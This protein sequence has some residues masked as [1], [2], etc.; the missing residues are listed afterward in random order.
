MQLSLQNFS[1]LVEGMAASVQGAAQSLLDL[2]VGSV[3]RAILEANASIALWLQWLIVQVLATTRL[4]TSSGAD[5]DSFGADFGFVR[6][7]A[8][9]AVGQVTFSR[10]T[11]SIAAF[12]PVGTNVSVVANT[13]SFV[14]VADTTNPSYS[15]ALGGYTLA[16]GVASLNVT[17]AASI[18]GSAGNVQPGSIALMSSAVSGVDTVTNMG[19]LTGG[20]DAESDAAFRARFGNYL[21]SLSRATDIAI[22]STIAGIQQG[23]SYT[24][25]ENINQAGNAQMGNFVVT[26]DDGSGNPSTNLL[27]AVQQAVGEIRPVGTSFAV[28]KPLVTLA[29]VAVTII[30]TTGTS[31]NAAVAAVG[32]AI[33]T[34]IAALPMGRT[35]S[36]TRLAQLAFDASS[37]VSNLSGLLLN[38]GTADLVP[39]LFGVVRV[40]IVTV[41]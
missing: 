41:A 26:V 7:P 4:A 17:V 30:T 40:G 3:L 25:S 10:F 35:L 36:Y 33:E 12:I 11:P 29:D 21:A 23:L 1:A 19:A 15:V 2:T 32:T 39:P 13:Q 16:A 28:Q 31:H 6:L 24:I 20:I 14:V 22:G 27:N 38:G 18:A 9:G 5:C 37:A 34:Y 8:V